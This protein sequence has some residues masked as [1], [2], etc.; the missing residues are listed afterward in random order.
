MC[1][2]F[3][4]DYNGHDGLGLEWTTYSLMSLST[5]KYIEF[6]P[7]NFDKILKTSGFGEILCNGP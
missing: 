1:P 2:K 3:V 4:N 5:N 7:R 6:P